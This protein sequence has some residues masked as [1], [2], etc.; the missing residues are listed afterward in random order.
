MQK[1]IEQIKKT[2][3]RNC[4]EQQEESK[5]ESPLFGVLGSQV[6]G[7]FF[8]VTMS[9][10]F[11]M[12]VLVEK[13]SLISIIIG[14]ICLFM[15][16]V[17]TTYTIMKISKQR[18]RAV[19]CLILVLFIIYFFSSEYRA[20]T[21]DAK[22][23]IIITLFITSVTVIFNFPDKMWIIVALSF[24]GQIVDARYLI[25]VILPLV[26]MNSALKINKNYEEYKQCKHIYS[27]S[28][29]IAFGICV[30]QIIVY[31][32]NLLKLFFSGYMESAYVFSYMRMFV[33]AYLITYLFPINK[34]N[35]L[36]LYSIAG[37]F[38]M[39]IFACF[40]STGYLYGEMLLIAL[41]VAY[42]YNLLK[43]ENLHEL[44]CDK[45][46]FLIAALCGI[47]FKNLTLLQ[48][49]KPTWNNLY[50]FTHYYLDYFHYGFVQRGLIGTIFYLIFGYEI[51]VLTMNKY[52]YIFYFCS[53]LLALLILYCI[54]RKCDQS[55]RYLIK[56][57]LLL[58]GIT[59][60]M[61][62]YVCRIVVQSVDV[63]G[64]LCCLMCIW[65]IL[66]KKFVF[67]VPVLTA[68]GMLNHQIFIFLFFPMI[69]S[70]LVYQTFVDESEKKMQMGI[71]LI[72]T[73]VVACGLF[74]FIQFVSA[75][76]LRID[77]NGALK[78]MLDRNGGKIIDS[79]LLFDGVI[80]DD[81]SSHFRKSHQVIA[82][83]K[84]KDIIW[85][86]IYFIPTFV[87]YI[88]I[89]KRSIMLENKK[90]KKI[91]YAVMLCSILAI[92]PCYILES[93]YFR[94]TTNLLW[95]IFI[96]ILVLTLM[97]P[98]E[99]RWDYGVK[100]EKIENWILLIAIMLGS[101]QDMGFSVFY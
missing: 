10:C 34:K 31:K 50:N 87:F 100:R 20:Y 6:M 42:L 52:I 56:L 89:Y 24:I 72:I 45:N 63:Y 85:T 23:L 93:D 75:Q 38:V 67:L 33:L 84:I 16:S 78:L 101:Y 98:K 64:L 74:L 30:I 22:L 25:M 88:K 60:A 73:S 47:C 82:Y 65:I 43:I 92:L 54:C 28:A 49:W 99:K 59:P 27:I 40:T 29:I 69:F 35:K 53:L 90:S 17:V 14:V 95:N 77:L 71:C 91:A 37:I 86:T 12:L 7:V 96:G 46:K 32:D 81:L 5:L 48:I 4:I 26:L 1:I 9:I 15:I 70:A 19:L 55:N 39:L 44:S 76:Y 57:I 66:N 8:F 2:S 80:F 97:Q 83:G 18:I 11:T 13:P 51:P 36:Y 58:I 94:W 21:Y 61:G 62:G 79:T 68:I 3:I 41:V